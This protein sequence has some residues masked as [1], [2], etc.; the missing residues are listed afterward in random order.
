MKLWK[1]SHC[2]PDDARGTGAT[3]A[4]PNGMQHFF[5]GPA[6]AGAARL[7]VINVRYGA[8]YEEGKTA[9]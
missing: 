3:S 9:G 2:P 6:I 7:P 5:L 8:T 1:L 4:N